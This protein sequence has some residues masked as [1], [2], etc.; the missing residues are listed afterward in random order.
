MNFDLHLAAQWESNRVFKFVNHTGAVDG[1]CQRESV[2][3][4]LPVLRA[5]RTGGLLL[6]A[7]VRNWI[8]LRTVRRGNSLITPC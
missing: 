8:F 1:Y 7:L 5:V 3:I 6:P 4:A 2:C